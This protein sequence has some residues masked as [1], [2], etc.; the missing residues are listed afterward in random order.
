MENKRFDY[1]KAVRVDV[2]EYLMNEINDWN[3]FATVDEWV[4]EIAKSFELRSFVCG[5]DDSEMYEYNGTY[6]ATTTEIVPYMT[7]VCEYMQEHMDADEID[8]AFKTYGLAVVDC[9]MRT[10]EFDRLLSNG[11]ELRKMASEISE[12][13]R[14]RKFD[15]K[16]KHLIESIDDHLVSGNTALRMYDEWLRNYGFMKGDENV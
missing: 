6:P 16:R 5:M 8:A 9:T 3:T 2:R 12:N 15:K 4:A 14:M 10:M 1:C 11:N 7:V 13:W